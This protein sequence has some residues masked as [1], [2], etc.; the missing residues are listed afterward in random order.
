[1]KKALYRID[2]VAEILAISR[3]SVYRLLEE[4]KLIAH[5]NSPGKSDYRVTVKSVEEYLA[6]YELPP[7][8]FKDKDIPLEPSERKM[9]SKGVE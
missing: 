6:K 9:I 2:E 3:A 4:G 5:C 7:E 1:M 8:Y